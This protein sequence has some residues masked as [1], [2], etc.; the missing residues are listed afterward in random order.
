[1]QIFYIT[2]LLAFLTVSLRDL[3]IIFISYLEYIHTCQNVSKYELYTE[4]PIPA[5]GAGGGVGAESV[6]LVLAL[7]DLPG[8]LPLVLHHPQPQRRVV[9]A[10]HELILDLSTH[11]RI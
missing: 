10:R 4:K 3:R 6:F 9:R 5:V 8:L 2:L 7:D 1:M 11:A